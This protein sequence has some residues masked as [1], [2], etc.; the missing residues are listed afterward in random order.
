MRRGRT[1]AIMPRASMSRVT[2]K[3]MKAAAARRPGGGLG[4]SAMSGSMGVTISGS[5]IIGFGATDSG[6]VID[7]DEF[8]GDS[9]MGLMAVYVSFMARSW[10]FRR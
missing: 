7:G 9:A 5:V 4:V 1:G 2:V 8:C 10:I 6:V 3:K